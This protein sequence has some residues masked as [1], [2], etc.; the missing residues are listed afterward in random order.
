[1]IK[2]IIKLLK[3]YNISAIDRG[4]LVYVLR[5]KA[6]RESV[7]RFYKDLKRARHE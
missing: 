7:R 2:K 5:A 6:S 1:M 3:K 4:A